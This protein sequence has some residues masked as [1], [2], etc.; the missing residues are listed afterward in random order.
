MHVRCLYLQRTRRMG[1]DVHLRN[2]VREHREKRHLG[3]WCLK[4]QVAVQYFVRALTVIDY[5]G[6]RRRII[7]SY[8]EASNIRHLRSSGLLPGVGS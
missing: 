7:N 4:F 8:F 5:L 6:I 1:W 3:V 2:F